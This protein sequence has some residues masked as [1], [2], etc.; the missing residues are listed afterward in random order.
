VKGNPKT[1]LQ[2]PQTLVLTESVAKKYFGSEEPLGKMVRLGEGDAQQT[3]EVTGVAKDIP[4]NSYIQFDAFHEQLPES[5]ETVL[6]LDMD[7]IGGI[8]CFETGEFN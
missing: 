2:S 7:S 5:E 6:E 8:C 3:Y 4:T 1:G